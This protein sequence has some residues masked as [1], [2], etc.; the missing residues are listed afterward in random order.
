MFRG[1][2]G[3]WS[4]RRSLPFVSTSVS[5]RALQSCGK[6]EPTLIAGKY[7]VWKFFER[8]SLEAT[9]GGGE[10]ALAA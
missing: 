9:D 3:H 5:A 1:G 2:D 4:E 8:A 7:A 6:E 10:V